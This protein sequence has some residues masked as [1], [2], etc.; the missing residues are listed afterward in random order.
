MDHVGWERSGHSRIGTS[1]G[2]TVLAGRTGWLALRTDWQASFSGPESR[3]AASLEVK[4]RRS[5]RV[6]SLPVVIADWD[7]GEYLSC[8]LL[9]ITTSCEKFGGTK[10]PTNR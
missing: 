9:E 2:C 1:G 6:I 7:G 3:R 10:R 4:G 5:G 8:F